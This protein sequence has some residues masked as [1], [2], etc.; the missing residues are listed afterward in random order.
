M[1]TPN[2]PGSEQGPE[3]TVPVDNPGPETAPSIPEPAVDRPDR[4]G[5]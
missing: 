1:T 5:R 4:D 2:E 3:P